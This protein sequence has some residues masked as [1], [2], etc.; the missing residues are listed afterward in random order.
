MVNNGR[1]LKFND[2]KELEKKIES[3]FDWCD[4]R[5][6][7]KHLVTKDGVQEV[8]ESFPRPYTV[9]GLAVYLNTNRQTLLNYN[10][11][12]G[13]FDIIEHARQRILSNKIKR[14]LNMIAIIPDRFCKL[15]RCCAICCF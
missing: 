5:T 13:F 10:E 7:V 6:R 1:P 12:D 3:Y 4:S 9:E 14:G 8:V 15:I 11:K 2:P